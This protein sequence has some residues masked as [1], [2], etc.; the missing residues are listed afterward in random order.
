MKYLWIIILIIGYIVAWVIFV[1][2]VIDEIGH[3]KRADSSK[4]SIIDF[5]EWIF[6]NDY[7]VGFL[8]IHGIVLFIVSLCMFFEG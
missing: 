1:L 3:C 5:I 2:K 7:V 6:S 8:I 4:P